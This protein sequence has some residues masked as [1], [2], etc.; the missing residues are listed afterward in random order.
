MAL[1]QEINAFYF[2]RNREELN[3]TMGVA[4]LYSIMG[5]CL[6][7]SGQEV[8]LLEVLAP[9]GLIVT[10]DVIKSLYESLCNER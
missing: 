7:S 10:H 2:H 4:I 1:D 6:K 5:G 3:L 9:Y 8:P